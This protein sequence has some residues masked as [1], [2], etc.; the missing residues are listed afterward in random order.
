MIKLILLKHAHLKAYRNATPF[1]FGLI[2]GEYTVGC[3]WNL[4]GII[5]GFQTYGFFES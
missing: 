5:L 4:L 2:L 3:L 1:F